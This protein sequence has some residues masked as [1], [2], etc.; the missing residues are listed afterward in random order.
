MTY[1]RLSIFK[2]F[3]TPKAIPIPGP[4][5]RARLKLALLLALCLSLLLPGLALA[6]DGALDPTFKIG[7]GPYAGVQTIPVIRGRVGYPFVT[8]APYNGY[9]LIFGNFL[10]LSVN[11]TA[12]PNNC[13]ARLKPNGTRDGA[14][15][16]NQM[17]QINGEIRGV[18][19][20]PHNYPVS[21]LQDKILIWGKFQAISGST[22]YPNL[23]R[24]NADGS[25]DTS[26]PLLKSWDG[27]VILGGSAGPR[28]VAPGRDHRQNPG[29]RL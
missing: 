9:N 21:D 28:W 14:F 11:G 23:A 15:L 7:P 22:V 5:P 1:H 26:F 19:I 10:G 27:A 24:L 6:G 3:D 13:L 25:L 20:Y 16:N 2:A 8:D 29:E 12:A 17:G 18:F 4:C